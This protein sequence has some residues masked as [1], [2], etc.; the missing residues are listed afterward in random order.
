MRFGK[1]TFHGEGFAVF[2]EAPYV[3][4]SNDDHTFG[5]HGKGSSGTAC[6][7]VPNI[8]RKFLHGLLS[9]RSPKGSAQA[10]HLFL[11]MLSRLCGHFL[12]YPVV[13]LVGDLNQTAFLPAFLDDF[14]T[15]NFPSQPGSSQMLLP[16]QPV[17]AFLEPVGRS[18]SYPGKEVVERREGTGMTIFTWSSRGWQSVTR[19]ET[20]H[21][22]S[23]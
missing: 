22:S 16:E 6:L 15:A 1:D 21:S 8:L 2:F 5:E 19:Q 9:A 11:D 14:D 20:C 3:P 12:G 10:R 4:N 17:L 23:R 18:E 13:V 7:G